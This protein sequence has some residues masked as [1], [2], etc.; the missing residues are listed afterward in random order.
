MQNGSFEQSASGR[1]G[2]V[3]RL[4]TRAGSATWIAGG[5]DGSR[6]VSISGSGGNAVLSGSPSWTS[7]PI[8]VTPGQM[9]DFAVA[10]RSAGASSAASAGLVYLGAAGQVIGAVTLITAPLTTS[11]FATLQ[12]TVAIPVGVAQVRVKL[13][14]FA[15]TDTATAGT[16]TFDVVGCT[17]SSQPPWLSSPQFFWYCSPVP[18][19]RASRMPF[20]ACGS[21]RFC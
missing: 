5:S 17:R 7:A 19:R 20:S 14:G 3:V 16:M 15:L 12:Q 2:C 8:T 6:S 4:D 18:T 9:L 11:S 21:G 13:T 1:S 10:V